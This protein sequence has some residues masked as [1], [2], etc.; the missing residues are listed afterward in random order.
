MSPDPQTPEPPG[1]ISAQTE[2]M[3][4]I[5]AAAMSP[6][7]RQAAE[8][9]AAGPRGGVKGPFIPLLRSPEL[10]DRLQ[11]VG[12]Y[13]RFNSALAPR[14]SELAILITARHWTQQFEWG[15]HAALAVA[16][17]VAP[18]TVASLAQGRHPPMLPADEAAA[19]AFG[20]ELLRTH[21]VSDATYRQAVEAFGEQGVIDLIGILG[22]FTTVSMVMNVARTRPPET[23]GLSPFPL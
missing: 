13:L 2:R 8:A 16:A 5:A 22:Y 20:E 3:P 12:E 6:A 4:P 17:G 9:L 10:M 15:V 14:I 19:Y 11:R 1:A 7:Q 21:G 23:P 18:E